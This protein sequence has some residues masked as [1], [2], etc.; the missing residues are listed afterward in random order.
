MG[1]SDDT[2]SGVSDGTSPSVRSMRRR[3]ILDVAESNPDA[4]LERLAAE[5]PTATVALVERVL[6][7]HGDPAAGD[8]H[9]DETDKPLET[10]TD[11]TV[12]IDE[13]SAKERRTLRAVYMNPEA[14][15]AE[16]G[17]IV[18]LSRS[19][20]SKQLNSI[21]GFEWDERYEF[22]SEYFDMASAPSE[23]GEITISAN[24]DATDSGGLLTAFLRK[25]TGK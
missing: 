1:K 8:T 14:T 4:S 13:L 3:K 10:D 2:T 24:D 11:S 12:A 19:M 9:H 25:L 6:N 15:Q 21:D 17:E 22:A 20:V 23:A 5:V 18:G 7:E 16:V